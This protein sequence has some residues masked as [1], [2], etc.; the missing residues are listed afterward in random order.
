MVSEY[1]VIVSEYLGTYKCYD[2]NFR[3]YK[4]TVKILAYSTYS[5]VCCQRQNRH[6]VEPA[7]WSSLRHPYLIS[8]AHD[9]PLETCAPGPRKD[10]WKRTSLNVG[11]NH[12][13]QLRKGRSW[14][15]CSYHYGWEWPL[16]PLYPT[17][18]K[19][20]AVSMG[21]RLRTMRWVLAPGRTILKHSQR[22]YDEREKC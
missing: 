5:T 10:T 11:P 4:M 20:E 22:F 8:G 7:K 18:V 15:T 21:E 19:C 2:L 12:P 16:T 17:W 6:P 3:T 1:S 14:P 13:R 9:D